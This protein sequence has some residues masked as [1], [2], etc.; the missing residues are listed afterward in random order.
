MYIIFHFILNELV[1]ELYLT[2]LLWKSFYTLSPLNEIQTFAHLSHQY[3]ILLKPIT[4]H[5]KCDV[6]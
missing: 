1:K 4:A 3:I 5:Y 2:D 6:R